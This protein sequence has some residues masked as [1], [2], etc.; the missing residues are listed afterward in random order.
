MS[1]L[2]GQFRTA[3]SHRKPSL[4][5][6]WWQREHQSAPVLRRAWGLW[7]PR[8]SPRG[9]LSPNTLRLCLMCCICVVAGQQANSLT[10]GPSDGQAKTTDGIKWQEATYNL[11][12]G[13]ARDQGHKCGLVRLF[14][15]YFLLVKSI[16][17]SCKHIEKLQ[18]YLLLADRRFIRR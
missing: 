6:V 17:R 3:A 12:L 13:S 16:Y 10:R 2:H 7:G 5:T 18:D 8:N 11:S 14:F 4:V 15:F 9:F 1:W